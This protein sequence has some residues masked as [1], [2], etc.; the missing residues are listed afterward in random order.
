MRLYLYNTSFIILYVLSYRS[1]S[2]EPQKFLVF[3]ISSFHKIQVIEI[4]KFASI[5][6]SIAIIDYNLQLFVNCLH[7]QNLVFQSCH[8]SNQAKQASQ[9]SNHC[10]HFHFT[11]PLISLI[12]SLKYLELLT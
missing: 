9:S 8:P 12:T 5:L 3:L 6:K 10:V 11:S 7:L 4:Y 2:S 1:S